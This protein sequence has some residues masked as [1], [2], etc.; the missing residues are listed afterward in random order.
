MKGSLL[1]ILP[2]LVFVAA[3][4]FAQYTRISVSSAGVQGDGASGTP[5]ISGDGRYVAFASAASNLVPGDTNGVADVFLHDRDTDADGIFDEPGAIATTRLSVPAGGGQ[6]DGPSSEPT[7]LAGDTVVFLSRATNLVMPALPSPVQR[8]FSVSRNG[9]PVE[10]VSRSSAGP[11]DGDCDG[12]SAGTSSTGRFIAYRSSSRTLAPG[13]P[14]QGGAIY[15]TT[16]LPGFHRTDRLSPPLYPGADGVQ[17]LV[18]GT[19]MTMDGGLIGYSITTTQV[20]NGAYGVQGRLFVTD[21]FGSVRDVGPGVLIRLDRFGT[22]FVAGHFGTLQSGGPAERHLLGSDATLRG[23]DNLEQLQTTQVSRTG[24]YAAFIEASRTLIHDFLSGE[25]DPVPIG[26][27]SGA[28]SENGRWLAVATTQA[29][30]VADDTNATADVVVVDL[31]RFFDGDGDGLDDRWERLSGLDPASAVGANGAAGDPDGDGITNSAEFAASHESSGSGLGFTHPNVQVRRYFAEGASNAFFTTQLALVN[32]DPA[33]PA[34]VYVR[35]TPPGNNATV[36]QPILVP[37]LGR[38]TARPNALVGVYGTSFAIEIESDRPV[39]VDRRM[40]WDV[41]GYGA[42]LETARVAP[43]STWYLAEGTTAADFSLFY[44]LQNPLD[45]PT[46]A[47]IRYLRPSGV[48]ILRTYELP[49]HSRLTVVVD[50]VDAGLRDSDVSAEIIADA[51]IVAERAMYATRHGQPFALGH[52]SA[53]VAAPA[54]DWFLAEGATG[55]F[56]DLYVLVANPSATTAEVDLHFLKPDGS[57]VLHHLS[58]PAASRRSV[59]VDSLAGL[60]TTPVATRAVAT[61]GVLIV[62]ERAMYWPGGF[63]DYEEGHSSAGSTVTATRWALGEGEDGGRDGAQSYVLIANVGATAGEARITLLGETQPNA[64]Q[65]VPLPA[66][67][68]VTVRVGEGRIDRF[69]VL[70]ESLGA[71]PAPIVV[72]GAY[73]WSPGGHIWAAGGNLLATP[74]TP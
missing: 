16:M 50:E 54:T 67:S 36:S 64:S 35:Y 37:P 63:F 38:R 6:A 49:A 20:V 41:T 57:E 70:V 2:A 56:F 44:L 11:A 9:G 29:S 23:P 46:T 68:R 71:A 5:A 30:L 14:G 74:L 47:T 55:T 4:A 39:V 13:D 24:R 12:V 60:E 1:P 28:W 7:F 31:E 62:V 17:P 25:T 34:A 45:T 69:G 53:G 33:H 43:S 18:S 42:S 52:V 32:P 72:E 51:P 58:V 26:G 40:T 22:T 15:V 65:V 61:N 3:P 8:V 10:L 73:Y 48:P 59:F 27:S 66:N 21:R 19:S